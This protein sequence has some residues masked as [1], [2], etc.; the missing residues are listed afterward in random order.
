[1]PVQFKK[2]EELGIK[3]ADFSDQ[4]PLGEWRATVLALSWPKGVASGV[5]I[6][7][8]SEVNQLIRIFVKWLPADKIYIQICEHTAIGDQILISVDLS[9][10]SK[11]TL[12]KS[13][14]KIV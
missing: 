14:Q 1:M 9:K 8:K 5:H 3:Y 6:F 10:R 12:I 11:K 4:P 2:L 13:I 7:L